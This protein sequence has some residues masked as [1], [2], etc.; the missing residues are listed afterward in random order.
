M[1]LIDKIRGC[2]GAW[3][4]VLKPIQQSGQVN[5][6][7][8]IALH[9]MSEPGSGRLDPQNAAVLQRGIAARCLRASG[10]L[11]NSG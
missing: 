9:R 1:R 8:Y 5:G 6:H 10:I 4:I 3:V 7:E 11:A 2:F